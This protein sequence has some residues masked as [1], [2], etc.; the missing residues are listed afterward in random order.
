MCRQ[1]PL[2][3]ACRD[4]HADC[5]KPPGLRAPD[6]VAAFQRMQYV[7]MGPVNERQRFA[8]MF[9]DSL[10]HIH[11]MRF[12]VERQVAELAVVGIFTP[13]RNVDAIFPQC[14]VQFREG[15]H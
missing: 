11:P 9:R 10:R 6:I 14:L 13:D 7:R 12:Q 3:K 8:R 1:N 4:Q 2:I 15:H 5:F